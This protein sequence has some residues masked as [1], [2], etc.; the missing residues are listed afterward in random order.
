[1]RC[2]CL[3]EQILVAPLVGG[4]LLRDGRFSDRIFHP[5]SRLLHNKVA[6]RDFCIRRLDVSPRDFYVIRGQELWN[7]GGGRES[8][9]ASCHLLD[10]GVECYC[11]SYY[12]TDFARQRLQLY[13]VEVVGWRIR[14]EVRTAATLSDPIRVPREVKSGQYNR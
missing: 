12:G 3:L 1:M 8:R 11:C 5:K 13:I 7:N 10:G 4:M 9:A 2:P 6:I 14:G